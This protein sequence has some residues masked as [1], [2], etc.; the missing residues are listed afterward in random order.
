[1][2]LNI[3]NCEAY[4]YVYASDAVPKTRV[5][6]TSLFSGQHLLCAQIYTIK[7]LCFV[8][9]H[10]VQRSGRP[11]FARRLFSKKFARRTVSK[12]HNSSRDNPVTSRI[13]SN[14]D[15]ESASRNCST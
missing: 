10:G 9:R 7:M 8:L 4:S 2:I 6:E 13:R 1:M 15:L 12:S 14:R 5:L 3:Q 11:M